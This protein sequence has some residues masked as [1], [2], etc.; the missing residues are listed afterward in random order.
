[1]GIT[2]W[3]AWMEALDKGAVY[4]D[5]TDFYLRLP[6]EFKGGARFYRALLGRMCPEVAQVPW[7]K[8]GRPLDQ[9]KP[10][11]SQWL[12]RIPLHQ[13][14]NLALM[15]LSGG[16]LDYSHRADLNLYFR[17]S[18]EFRRFFTQILQD[19]RTTS[20]GIIDTAGIEK[21]I[22]F[23]DK[24]WPVF[25]LLQSLVTVELWYRRHIDG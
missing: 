13:M 12:G 9:D 4:P 23:V 18:V 5:L 16:R 22:G 17:R 8:T 14:A 1:M 20:R 21:L 6:P 25:A 3:V 15:R 7:A 19:P 10:G 24:G 11:L 2:D